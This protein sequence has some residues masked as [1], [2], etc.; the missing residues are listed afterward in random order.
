M[1]DLIVL[2]CSGMALFLFGANCAFLVNLGSRT[3]GWF[4]FKIA[5]I[6]LLL[7]YVSLS[8]F[9]GAPDGWR[10]AIGF[11]ALLL[12]IFALVWMW[13]SIEK[14]SKSGV[15]GLVPLVAL[16]DDDERATL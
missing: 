5:A 6:T 4:K 14:M 7:G 9:M 15:V 13:R 11:C 16:T 1:Y 8:M 10:V 2:L 12:D 3:V